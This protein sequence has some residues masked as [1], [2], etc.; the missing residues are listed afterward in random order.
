M[1]RSW[2]NWSGSIAFAPRRIECPR[3][4]DAICALV[5]DAC[6]SDRTL[7]VVGA[8]HSSSDIVR[9][10]DTL[11]SLRHFKGIVSADRGACEAT[12]RAGSTLADLGRELYTHDLAMPNY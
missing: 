8:G 12:V 5:A 4:E 9:C 2:R 11:V 3:D 7:R 6:A 1:A 10:D